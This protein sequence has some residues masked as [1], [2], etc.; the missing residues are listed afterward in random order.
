MCRGHKVSKGLGLEFHRVSESGQSLRCWRCQPLKNKG[1]DGG[2]K[3]SVGSWKGMKEEPQA[4]WLQPC[5]MF[6]QK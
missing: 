2:E 5:R 3:I 6:A 4:L 1:W